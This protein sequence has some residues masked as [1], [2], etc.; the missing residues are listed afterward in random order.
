M[1]VAEFDNHIHKYT[2]RSYYYVR[3][4]FT[5]TVCAAYSNCVYFTKTLIQSLYEK[6]K[7]FRFVFLFMYTIMLF[8]ISPS[9]SFCLAPF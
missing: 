8:A 7:L 5:F 4:L 3:V 1:C 2:E 6:I 9:L